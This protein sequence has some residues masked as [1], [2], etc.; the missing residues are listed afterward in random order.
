M[1]PASTQ[2]STARFSL[3]RPG[4][5]NMSAQASTTNCISIR[6]D[7]LARFLPT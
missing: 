1:N 5:L 7:L 4:R 2:R 6:M 3:G